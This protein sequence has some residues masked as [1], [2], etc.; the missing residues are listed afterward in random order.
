MPFFWWHSVPCSLLVCLFYSY[1]LSHIAI[2]GEFRDECATCQSINKHVDALL[3]QLG[4]NESLSECSERN[5]FI[6]R[7]GFAIIMAEPFASLVGRMCTERKLCSLTEFTVYLMCFIILPVFANN[8][9]AP[10]GTCLITPKRILMAPSNHCSW[11]RLTALYPSDPG[12]APHAWFV[13]CFS[14]SFFPAFC[15]TNKIA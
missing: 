14:F 11:V 12:T 13:A 6:T 2:L 15:D 10:E 7:I 8:V 5:A 3:W 1:N 9:I 4:S